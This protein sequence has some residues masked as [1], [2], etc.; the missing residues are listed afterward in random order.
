MAIDF[1]ERRIGVAVEKHTNRFGPG[2]AIPLTTLERTTDRRAAAALA[3]LAKEHCV[4]RL[5]VGE[6]RSPDNRP[7]ETHP[8]VVA[9][10]RRLEQRTRLPVSL[11]VETLT[12]IEAEARLRE[13][14]SHTFSDP[15]RLDA[16]AAQILLEEYLS[17]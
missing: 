15:G 14:G 4:T 1:G 12:S 13:S 17:S 2:L 16:L 7:S 10:A 9:F 6:P 3:A 11:V 8:R 5:V